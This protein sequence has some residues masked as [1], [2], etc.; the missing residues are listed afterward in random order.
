M[1]GVKNT[2]NEEFE[3]GKMKNDKEFERDRKI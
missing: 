1:I 2:K 3:T